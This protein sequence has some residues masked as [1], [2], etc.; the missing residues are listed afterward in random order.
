MLKQPIINF[1]SFLLIFLF[2]YTAS[3]KLMDMHAFRAVLA[4][5]PGIKAFAG[6]IAVAIPLAELLTAMLLVMPVTRKT[7]LFCSA[8]LLLLFTFFLLYMLM[9]ADH[10]PCS[11]GGV[12]S[13][14][15][16]QQHIAF[17]LFFTA[18]S[19]IA[20]YYLQKA[21]REQTKQTSLLQ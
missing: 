3:S 4:A 2:V 19:V 20:F 18:L 6:F 16:W 17:N 7:G 9:T 15:S 13:S 8:L 1:I 10:L 21:R 5:M 12:I 14:M 11:C